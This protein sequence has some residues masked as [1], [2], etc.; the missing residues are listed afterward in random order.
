MQTQLPQ[1]FLISLIKYDLINTKLVLTLNRI[2]I[3]ADDY[4]TNLST[5][6]F[7]LMGHGGGTAFEPLYEGYRK[8]AERIVYI[9]VRKWHG[10]LETLAHEIYGY[11]LHY[12]K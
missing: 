5:G 7:E 6:I 11:L 1:P 3:Y 10:E 4:L 8:L 9:D 2:G 12:G